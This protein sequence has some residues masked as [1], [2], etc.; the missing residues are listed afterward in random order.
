MCAVPVADSS[1]VE[2]G[3]GEHP[4]S[5]RGA[6]IRATIALLLAL[7]MGPAAWAQSTAPVPPA[8]ERESPESDLRRQE[9][10]RIV[11]LHQAGEHAEVVRAVDE[12]MARHGLTRETAPLLFVQAE[13]RLELGQVE[14]A[15]KGYDTGL[16][17]L[18][19]LHNVERR[20]FAWAVFRLATALRRAGRSEAA[21]TRLEDGLRLEPQNVQYQILRGEMLAEQGQ[22]DRALQLFQSLV[23]S[24][25]ANS[26]ERA[27]LGIKI[28]RLLAGAPAAAAASDLSAAS[29]H[30][31]F[32]IGLVLV[33]QSSAGIPL[34]DLCLV[35]ESK[36]LIRC[37]VLA[38]VSIPEELILVAE[39][40]QYAGDKVLQEL[41]RHLPAPSRR[42]PYVVGITGRDIFGPR[43]SFV[44]S[45][46]SRSEASGIGIISTHRFRA[47]V[48]DF[49]EPSFV[50]ARR[51]AIQVLS[52]TGSM[53]GFTRPPECPLAY[54]NEV[55]EFQQKRSRLCE[56]DIEQRDA[57]LRRRG[58]TPMPFGAERA[59]EVER[60][61][62]AYALE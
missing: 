13:S 6:T 20:K 44:F 18:A 11:K 34:S 36:W 52:T 39:R 15:I 4:R 60:V 26:E 58:G 47:G 46:Q 50:T 54:P 41:W 33:N 19:P 49:Y 12:F 25:L 3:V 32:S 1:A 62:R 22:R 55:R 31:G 29:L 9:G 42:H 57:L 30:T 21:L 38:P 27:V 24:S 43:T 5:H 28:G 53:L 14:A 23:G 45:W 17:A 10:I 7:A 48:P 35:L 56:S 2:C 8:A 16:A 61:Y 40:G 59:A 51:R 37:E